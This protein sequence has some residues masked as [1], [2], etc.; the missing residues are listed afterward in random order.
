MLI[1]YVNLVIW[2]FINYVQDF[3]GIK[4]CLLTDIRLI[5]IL[6][7]NIFKHSKGNTLHQTDL[8]TLF[9]FILFYFVS[10]YFVYYYLINVQI[11]KLT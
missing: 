9:Y 1:F 10:F 7:Q 3:V 6:L 8:A 5:K 11:A 4:R 2:T